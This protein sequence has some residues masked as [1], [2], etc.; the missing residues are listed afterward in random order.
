ML[1][2]EM[3]QCHS[4]LCEFFP[5]AESS[6]VR[7]TPTKISCGTRVKKEHDVPSV[8][9]CVSI[10]NNIDNFKKLYRSLLANRHAGRYDLEFILHDDGSTRSGVAQDAF[11]FCA[12]HKI[13]F[14]SS[15]INRG[16]AASWNILC[17]QANADIVALLNDDLLCGPDDWTGHIRS[18]FDDN[19]K[20]GIVY[21]CQ[22]IVDPTTGTMRRFTTD[23]IRTLEAG[24]PVLRHNFCGAFFAFRRSIWRAIEQPDGST[25]FWEDLNTYGE[26]FDFSAETLRRGYF[27]LQL[28]F[29]WD[30]LHSQTF[31]AYPS[32][33]K[34]NAFS[35]YLSADEFTKFCGIQTSSYFV[36]A[37]RQIARMS[38]VGFKKSKVEIPMG[39][40]SQ[41]MLEKKWRDKTILGF[42]G[43]GFLRQMRFDGFPA[44]LRVALE[45]GAFNLPDRISGFHSKA[46]LDLNEGSLV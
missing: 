32:K 38:K 37:L 18:Y 24:T 11:E 23:S 42:E 30:H 35:S 2:R 7:L 27:I 33:R 44:A 22:R 16:V 31:A 15:P 5:K 40:Y 26:E 4:S 29:T 13:R 1:R 8:S 43:S 10:Y 12:Q 9:V 3:R 21:W 36:R 34:R 20:L 6:A 28:P 25:G 46:L 45:R 17:Q 41:A 14:I 39:A 19:P